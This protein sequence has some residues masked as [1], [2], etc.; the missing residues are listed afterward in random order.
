M[1]RIFA[2]PTSNGVLTYDIND[3]SPTL[4]VYLKSVGSKNEEKKLIYLALSI[5]L[6]YIYI[7]YCL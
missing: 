2:L 5:T 6:I 1:N 3:C 7:Q 4:I